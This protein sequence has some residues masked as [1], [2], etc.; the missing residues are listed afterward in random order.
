MLL[1][2][3]PYSSFPGDRHWLSSGGAANAGGFGGGGFQAEDLLHA[4]APARCSLLTGDGARS[5]KKK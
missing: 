2:H 5:Q 4:I 1:E 3:E